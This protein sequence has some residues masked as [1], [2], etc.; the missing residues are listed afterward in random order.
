MSHRPAAPPRTRSLVR[1][2]HCSRSAPHALARAYE[3]ALP[4]L[5]LPVA[6]PPPAA[7]SSP[8]PGHRVVSHT[9]AGA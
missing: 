5:R 1:T 6:A 9:L 8:V 2:A 7:G 4:I 3:L